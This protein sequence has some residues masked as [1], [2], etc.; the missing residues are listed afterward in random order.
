MA[1]NDIFEAKSVNVQEVFTTKSPFY[2][3]PAY[4]RQYS[5]NE[6]KLKKLFEDICH[7]YYLLKQ[8]KDNV[9]FIG[10]IILINDREN[11][12][13]LPENKK[14]LPTLV[15]TVIDGQQRLTSLLILLSVLYER[16]VRLYSQY[17]F[18]DDNENEYLLKNLLLSTIDELRKTFTELPSGGSPENASHW[19]PRMTRAYSDIWDRDKPQYRSPIACHLTEFGK[20]ARKSYSS[21]TSPST[22][23]QDQANGDNE[24]LCSE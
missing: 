23:P 19:Y 11:K 16:L 9:T 8:I 22:H 4:Q 10:S 3:I 21:L 7:G 1:I 24:R 17:K 5:W 18:D 12:S 14:G 2:F 13:V 20:W 6:P 15:L